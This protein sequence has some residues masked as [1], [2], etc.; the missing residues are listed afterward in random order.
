[1]IMEATQDSGL[2]SR[3]TGQINIGVIDD[4]V[5]FGVNG[6]PI[7]GF[8]AHQAALMAAE[9]IK[10]A[11]ALSVGAKM[12]AQ[13]VEDVGQELSDEATASTNEPHSPN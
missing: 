13:A 5:V 7:V 4:K 8:T 11:C 6:K 1:M 10:H 3:P 2:S 9:L 12:V